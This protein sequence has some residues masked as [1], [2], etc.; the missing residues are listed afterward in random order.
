MSALISAAPVATSNVTGDFVSGHPHQMRIRPVLAEVPA[1]STRRRRITAA[2]AAAADEAV[3]SCDPGRVRNLRNIRTTSRAADTPGACVVLPRSDG[4][5]SPK[6]YLLGPAA[7]TGGD[8]S[9]VTVW[10]ERAKTFSLELDLTNSGTVAFD[11]FAVE[12]FHQ[13]IAVTIDGSVRATPTLQSRSA[14]VEPTGGLVIFDL[15]RG[16]SHSAARALA[17]RFRAARVEQLVGFANDTTMTTR[18]REIIGLSH[19]RLD[20]K[21]Q[22]PKDC[23][24]PD[25]TNALILGCYS[26]HGLFVL[27]VD[28]PDFAPVMSVT[29]AHEM[30]H[31]AYAGLSDS[32]RA[33]VDG[34]IETFYGTLDDPH[35]R[36][37]MAEYEL[38]EPGRRLDELHSLLP[39]QIRTMSPELERYYRRYFAHRALI[40]DAFDKYNSVFAPLRA[41]L[42]ELQGT[43]EATKSRLDSL[44]PRIEAAR[45]RARSLSS[46]IEAL[47]AQGRIEESNALVGPQNA[48]VDDTNALVNENNGLVATFNATLADLQAVAKDEL[49]LYNSISAVPITPT[50]G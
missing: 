31:A 9:S 28:R 23:A 39:T 42:A 49:G 24:V 3:A 30:L 16:T 18:A 25:S 8:I 29:T 12:R 34:L 40:V 21:A 43:L 44:L 37:L 1:A 20:D 26:S 36:D 7:V 2:Q 13:K 45:S 4:G 14:V 35:L 32:E 50:S 19:P 27:R 11:A 6:R 17:V 15:P 5:G 10:H 46:Q 38:R 33:R 47:R 22:F 41:R 48:A